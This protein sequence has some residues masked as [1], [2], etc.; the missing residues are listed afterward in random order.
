M[1]MEKALHTWWPE[2]EYLSPV[3][4]GNS[5]CRT[6]WVMTLMKLLKMPAKRQNHDDPKAFCETGDKHANNHQVVEIL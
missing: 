5:C 6:V 4:L 3:F 2:S 1:A